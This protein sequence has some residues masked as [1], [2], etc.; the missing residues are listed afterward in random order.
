[1]IRESVN[2]DYIWILDC[3]FEIKFKVERFLFG[4][5]CFKLHILKKKIGG[6]DFVLKPKRTGSCSLIYQPGFWLFTSNCVYT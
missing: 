5:V 1:M 2:K 3:Q 4:F 6:G